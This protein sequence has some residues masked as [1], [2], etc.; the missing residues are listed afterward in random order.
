MSAQAL[1]PESP[2]FK[3][4]AQDHGIADRLDFKLLPQVRA[5]ID[6]G[7]RVTVE[8]PIVNIDRSFGAIISNYL[9]KRHGEAGMPAG[10]VRF[11]LKGHA[12]QSLGFVLARGISVSVEGDAND[13][14]GKGLSGGELVVFPSSE[15][16]EVRA[17]AARAGGVAH[18]AP[19]GRLH[20]AAQ[21][22][23]CGALSPR[24]IA[25]RAAPDRTRRAAHTR[26]P[27]A[28]SARSRSARTRTTT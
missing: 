12:G 2:M 8:S 18:R 22:A 27:P 14:A 1:N 7:T 26:A 3:T 28:C 17:R 19:V 9:S 10:S 11:V 20:A 21:R 13:Y 16:D 5:A 25:L 15:L 24:A 4:M 23:P 6:A